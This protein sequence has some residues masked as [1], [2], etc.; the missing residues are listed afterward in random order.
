MKA[1]HK[2]F[3]SD[4]ENEVKE[5]RD[6]YYK[7]LVMNRESSNGMSTQFLYILGFVVGT[8]VVFLGKFSLVSYLIGI[9]FMLGVDALIVML[10]KILK[11]EGT[12]TYLNVIR[13]LGYFSI[14]DYEKKLRRYVIGKGGYYEYLLGELVQ[15]YNINEN[16]RKVV[17]ING[18]EFYIWANQHQDKINLLNSKTNV[19]PEVKSIRMAS[20]R[21]YRIDMQRHMVVLKTDIEE[22]YFTLQAAEVFNDLIKMKRLENLI[23]FNPGDYIND[24]ELYMHGMRNKVAKKEED[25]KKKIIGYMSKIFFL[26]LIL[27]A[28]I[29]IRFVLE[30]YAGFVNLLSLFLLFFLNHLFKEMLVLP[31]LKAKSEDDYIRYFERNQECLE[32]FGEL[33]Y[34]LGISD[35]YDRVYTIEGACYLTWVANG[36][37]H[38]FLNV[39]YFNVVYMAINLSDVIYYKAEGN[40]CLLKLKDKTLSF[41]SAAQQVFAKILPNKDYEWLKGYQNMQNM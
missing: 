40:E 10:V 29:G 12:N 7:N 39:I 30:D 4:Y 32:K 35:S 14:D 28:M 31:R 27:G 41:T 22:L 17:G 23:T 5:A 20:I 34:A 1:K 3:I 19:R 8:F 18:E 21:Y 37:F 6:A 26:V 11:L 33:K 2:K 13:R 16:V 9:T 15:T 38:V 36:Y 25:L 24:F